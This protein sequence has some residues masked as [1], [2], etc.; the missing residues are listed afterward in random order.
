MGFLN[1]I[2]GGAAKVNIE[3]PAIAFPSQAVTVSIHVEAKDNFECKAVYIDVV[4]NEHLSFRPQ[5]AQ[6]DATSST[7]TFQQSFQVGPGFK[8]EK[9][10]TKELSGSFTLPR[11]T[12]PTYHGKYGKHTW[13]IQA[14]LEAKGNDPDSGWK[15]IR[16]GATS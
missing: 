14:R 8:L 5:G 7:N 11:E 13:Q 15:E 2:T 10:Q 12:Q 6:Q 9:G 16:V 3:L 4:G 1:F